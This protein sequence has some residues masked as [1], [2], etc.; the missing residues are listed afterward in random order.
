[1][2]SEYPNV[3][4]DGQN[5]R[6]DSVGQNVELV[7]TWASVLLHDVDSMKQQCLTLD[8]QTAVSVCL[9][10]VCIHIIPVFSAVCVCV[11]VFVYLSGTVQIVT[12]FGQLNLL[13]VTV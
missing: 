10:T 8:R 2:Y 9:C 4:S 13:F 1:M 11:C 6:Y 3:P 5:V 12:E 7:M